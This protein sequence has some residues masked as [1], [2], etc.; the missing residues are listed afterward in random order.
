MDSTETLEKLKD[1]VK[2]FCEDREWDQYHSPK[3]LAIGLIT[4]ASE[5]LEIFRFKS[6]KEIKEILE[7]PRKREMI[8]DELADVLYFILRFSQMYGFDISSEIDRKLKKN[9][10]RYPVQK[11]KGMNKKYSEY[12]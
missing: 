6:E 8:G 3:E 11:S 2:K 4:E 10:N 7:D 12:V 5:L 9:E 1:S